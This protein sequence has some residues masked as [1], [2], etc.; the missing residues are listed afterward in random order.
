LLYHR[1]RRCFDNPFLKQRRLGFGFQFSV[2][3]GED[4]AAFAILLAEKTGN[5]ASLGKR[6]IELS[7]GRASFSQCTTAS[8]AISI[9]IPVVI[10]IVMALS[11][12]GSGGFTS[13][14][15]RSAWFGLV[16]SEPRPQLQLQLQL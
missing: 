14:Q 10:I 13:V 3:G 2:F 1:R 9:G 4:R 5:L 16:G 7:T 11:V 12:S 8:P 15:F 6:G